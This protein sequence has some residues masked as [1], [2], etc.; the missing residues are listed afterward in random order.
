[1]FLSFSFSSR[2]GF[3]ASRQWLGW[4]DQSP[5]YQMVL[6]RTINFQI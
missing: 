2:L 1:L 4:R 6:T 5:T 3:F